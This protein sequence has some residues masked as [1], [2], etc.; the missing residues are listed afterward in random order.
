MQL[1]WSRWIAASSIE[2]IR[3]KPLTWQRAATPDLM[4]PANRA[5]LVKVSRWNVEV[6]NLEAT[7]S[8]AGVA[9]K[10]I[11]QNGGNLI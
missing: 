10:R 11:D 5:T 2:P 6:G 9:A 8:D 1:V 3:Q 4:R 7:H